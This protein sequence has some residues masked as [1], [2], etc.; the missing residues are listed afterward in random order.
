MPYI[1]KITRAGKIIIVERYYSSRYGKK[2][3]HRS[4]RVKPTSEEQKKCN[5]RRQTYILAAL[6]AANFVDGD[7]H[8]DFGYKRKRGEGYRT[9]EEMRR[10]ADRFLRELRKAYRK[11]GKVLR[12]VHVME[13]GEKGSRHH[14]MVLNYMDLG[15]IRE[16]WKKVYMGESRIH[17]TPLDTDGDYQKLA[18]YLIKYTDAVLGTEKALQGKRWNCSR[19]LCRPKPEYRIVRASDTFRH[20]PRPVKGYRIVKDSLEVGIHSPE[21]YGYG[22]IRYRMVRLPEGGK[23]WNQKQSVFT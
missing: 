18:Q 19:N 7:L 1:E 17:A 14:H 3:L 23:Q 12:Y 2:G 10:D 15:I 6:L 9:R 22:F 8:I 16:C 5:T 21:Y 20:D 4:D 11:E 13:V